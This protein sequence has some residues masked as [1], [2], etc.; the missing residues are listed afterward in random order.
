MEPPPGSEWYNMFLGK[1][2]AAERL[3][4]IGEVVDAVLFVASPKSNWITGQYLAVNGG[5]A[6][7]V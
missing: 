3:G 6:G 2:V 7:W 5:M 1:I 4:T